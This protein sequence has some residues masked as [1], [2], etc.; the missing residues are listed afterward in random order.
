MMDQLDIHSSPVA[1]HASPDAE[2]VRR[3]LLAKFIR[4]SLPKIAVVGSGAALADLEKAYAIEDRPA[5]LDFVREHSLQDL[6]R[7][8]VAPL[9]AA[10]GSEPTKV[11]RLEYDPD[12]GTASLFCLVLISSNAEAALEARRVFENDWW[13]ERSGS[14]TDLN[15]DFELV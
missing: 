10:F 4:A 12:D 2:V 15:F 3:S 8:A 6:L 13:A 5:V 7:E 11:L 14:A 9:S 1:S